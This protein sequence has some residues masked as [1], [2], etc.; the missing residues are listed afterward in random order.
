MTD[1]LERLLGQGRLIFTLVTVFVLAGVAAFLYMD[2]QED[3]SF[4]YRAG[5]ITVPFPG[6]APDR[7]ERLVLKPLE[8]QIAEVEQVHLIESTA[9]QGVALVTVE[10]AGSVYDTDS[11]WDRVRVA[12]D[13]ARRDYPDGVGQARLNDRVIDASTVLLAVTG[14][15]DPLVLVDAA[16]KLRKRMIGLDEV[17]STNLF[18]DPGK[19][20]TIAIDDAAIAR[21]RL[22]PQRIANDIRANNSV[23]AGGTILLA[24]ASVNLKPNTDYDSIDDIRATA[25]GLP[26]GGTVPLSAIAHVYESS[27]QP[28]RERVWFQGERAVAVEVVAVRETTDVVAFGRRVR[29]AAQEMRP[30]LAPLQIEEMFYQPAQTEQRLANLTFNLLASIAIILG[31]L[32]VFMGWRMGVIVAVLLPLVT[33]TAIAL[34]ALGGGVLQQMAVIGLVVALGILVDNAIVMTE[35][36]Q[37]HLNGGAK[38]HDAAMRSVRELAGP[39]LAATGTTL[40]AFVPML[41]ADGNSADFIRALPITIMLALGVSYLYAVTVTPL[42]SQRFLRAQAR[43]RRDLVQRL[44]DGLAHVTARHPAAWLALGVAAIAIALGCMRFV[45]QEFFPKAD[46]ATVI[47]DITLPEGTHLTRTQ[48]TARELEQAL[49]RMTGVQ[50]VHGFIGTGGPKFYYNLQQLPEAPQR[51]RLVVKTDG[52]ERNHAIIGAIERYSADHLPAADVVASV[53][54]Q[55]PP[56]T[57]PIEL[58][59]F[60]DDPQRLVEATETIFNAALGIA[61]TRDVR[62]DLGTGVPSLDYTIEPAVAR[63]FGVTP[64][65]VAEALRGRSHGLIVGQYRAGEDPV[66]IKL[67]SPEGEHFSP[68]SLQTTSVYNAQGGAVPLMQVA[69]TRLAIEPGAIRHHNQRRVAHV[70]SELVEGHVYSQVLTPLKA[71]VAE[72]TLPAGTEVE[73]GGDA[74]ESGKANAALFTAAPL[75]I[76]LLLFFLLVQFNS[77]IRVGLV[78]LTAPFALVGVVPGLLLL[79]I[80][81]GFQPLLGLFALTGIVVNNAIVLIDVID[82]R[83]RHGT[84]LEAAIAEAV[85]RRTRPIL[86]TTAT[87]IAGLLPLAFSDTTLWPPLAWPI[88][89][90]LLA[91]TVLTLIVLPAVC[92]LTMKPAPRPHA[93]TSATIALV[94]GSLAVVGTSAP[95]SAQSET[96]DTVARVSFADSIRLAPNRARVTADRMQAEAAGSAAD[97]AR[98]A[99]RYPTLSANAFVSRSDSVARIDTSDAAAL[100]DQPLNFPEASIPVGSRDKRGATVEL[101]QPVIDAAA[102]LYDGPAAAETAGAATHTLARSRV[103]SMADGANAYLDALS[104]AAR[105]QANRALVTNLAARARRI[106]ALQ[107][108]G[109]ALRSD[110]LEVDY[111]KREA[112]Q[113]QRSLAQDMA[114]ARTA[115]GRA[116]GLTHPVAPTPLAFEAPAVADNADTLTEKAITRRRDIAALDARVRA[117]TLQVKSASAQRLPT[118]DA[119]ASLHYNEGSAFL[120]EREGRIAAQ[121]TWTPFAGG[122]ISAAK[123][124]AQARLAA[125]RAQR[126]ELLNGVRLEITRALADLQDSRERVE[127]ATLGVQSATG[128]RD[129]RAARL[130]AGRAN[131]DDLLDAEATLAERQAQAEIARYDVVRAWVSVQEATGNTAALMAAAR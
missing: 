8:E 46:R 70:Y 106:A 93:T 58:R 31:I 38:P 121:V 125:L 99:G 43:S 1:P 76:A 118:L 52:L 120:P 29:A 40:A 23:A 82:D 92:Q 112:R 108:D 35:N 96:A 116:L 64:V 74:E 47:V 13:D 39:L 79:Q 102:Q 11:A 97:R 7:I 10:L 37:W 32:F 26:G 34:Y 5:L 98:R 72:L 129:T 33:L 115:L 55:G 27:A 22:S 77:F 30:E 87:T 71:R 48:Q 122:T 36:V 128:T 21:Y 73:Y 91:S 105:A 56:V 4:P 17:S 127:L 101:R 94:I 109:R 103:T 67:R 44:A 86:L 20:V 117:A 61:G 84:S 63:S 2:R 90:G 25:I 28:P 130:E 18:G 59:V 104:V 62:H 95:A 78:L 42:I 88:I 15:D 3:P 45:D 100:F 81:F 50:T 75:G 124:E 68:T 24:G 57:A 41:L 66:P 60:N 83:W 107:N 65:D 16:K 12:M 113:Q 131:V 53:L 14:S 9:R 54:S 6:A 85:R 111:R 126:T 51:A 114:V 80:P 69:I 19:Q 110:V 119:V 49:H 123:G 89:T